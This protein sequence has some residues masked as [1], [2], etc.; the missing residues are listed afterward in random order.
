MVNVVLLMNLLISEGVPEQDAHKLICIAKHE[1]NFNSK[2]I[3]DKLNRNKTIDRGLF[4]VNSVHLT[5][6]NVTAEQL[7]DVRTNVSCAVKIYELQ[8]LKAW[9]TLKFCKGETYDI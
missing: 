2:A 5:T 4:Q 7:F 9:A 8:G 6:C 1:S 3:N